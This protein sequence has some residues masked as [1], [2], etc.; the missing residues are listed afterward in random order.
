M[1]EVTQF[2]APSRDRSI[3]QMLI[4]VTQMR[5]ELETADV[6]RR[7]LNNMQMDYC[8][9][10]AARLWAACRALEREASDAEIKNLADSIDMTAPNLEQITWRLVQK[11]S[12]KGSRPICSFPPVLKAKQYLISDLLHAAR[13]QTRHLFDVKGRGMGVAIRTIKDALE[14]G[15]DWCWT[16]DVKDCFQSVNPNN[17]TSLLPLPR[18]V[19][20]KCL[21]WRNLNISPEQDV[22]HPGVRVPALYVSGDTRRHRPG[23][24][25]QGGPASNSVLS[26]LFTSMASAFDLRECV[27]C[28]IGD[29][30]FVAARTEADRDAVVSAVRAY[31]RT[32]SA[33]RFL[34]HAEM[35]VGPNQ[36]FKTLGFEFTRECNKVRVEPAYI[37]LDR[38]YEKLGRA[39]NANEAI[40]DGTIPFTQK[41]VASYRGVYGIWDEIDDVLEA[42]IWQA[43]KFADQKSS[44]TADVC[45]PANIGNFA[46]KC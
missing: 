22:R 4:D 21:D 41:L 8:N 12:R 36:R 3:G 2:Y 29:N 5:N 30:L 40:G 34:L 37:A 27:P 38:M 45:Y 10:A 43:Q 17:L 13:P 6:D 14:D 32:H 7:Q 19:V 25:L 35:F 20:S 18:S 28:T 42:A 26:T 39:E 46:Y 15:F 33:G 9:S 23:G 44:G 31:I 24:L 11:K 1:S 16:G